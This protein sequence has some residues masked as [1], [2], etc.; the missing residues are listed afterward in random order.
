VIDIPEIAPPPGILTTH[1]V[2]LL[3]VV[4]NS[5]SMQDKQVMFAQAATDMLAVLVNPPCVDESGAIV[6]QPSTPDA[7]CSTGTRR[8]PPVRDLHAGV[9]SSSLGGHGNPD[10]CESD[11]GHNDQGHLI[12]TVRPLEVPDGGYGFVAWG[13]DTTADGPPRIVAVDELSSAVVTMIQGAGETGCGYEAQLEAWYRFLVDPVPPASVIRDG[14]LTVREGIDTVLLE[15]RKAFLRPD[16]ALV[17]AILSDENDCSIMDAGYGWLAGKT[18]L[19][20]ATSACAEDPNDPCCTYCGFAE[21]PEGCLPLAE[22]PACAASDNYQNVRCWDQKRRFGIEFRYPVTRYLAGLRDGVVCPDSSAVDGDCGCRM[23]TSQGKMC[24]PGSP[25][26]NPIYSDLTGTGVPV[27][28][29]SLVFLLSVGGVPWQDLATDETLE[30][31]TELVYKTGSAIDWDLIL[32]DAAAGVPPLDTLMVESIEPR[33]GPPHP[34][35]GVAP[36]PPESSPDANPINGHEWL[37][38]NKEDLQY[39]CIFPLEPILQGATRD[40]NIIAQQTCDCF[41]TTDALE[42]V[43]NRMKPLCQTETGEYSSVQRYAKAY[44]SLR[45]LELVRMLG[46]VG[47]AA[48]ICPKI[49]EP[50][51]PFFGYK[52]AVHPLLPSLLRVI[53]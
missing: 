16:S 44:P 34:L 24:D 15:Q 29:S 8:I 32:G 22:D 20:V 43:T 13:E 35:T 5:A 48:S 38:Q 51:S 25:V 9:I 45:Q 33:T 40:C 47:F 42:Q 14:D 39:A 18:T 52:P 11:V 36:Q 28:D 31:D 7:A 50:T 27:R 30:S 2:D 37:P 21:A 41:D 46:P 49:L 23:A 53:E 4:D 12:A 6:D 1:K 19:S 17:I 26:T 3:F 10:F